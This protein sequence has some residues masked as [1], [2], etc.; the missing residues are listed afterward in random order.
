MNSLFDRERFRRDHRWAPGRMSE[1]LDGELSLPGRGRM[2]HHLAECQ[3]CRRLLA[4]LRQTV[5]ALARL[6]A[7]REGVDPRTIAASVQA[8]L[9]APD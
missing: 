5:S 7:P 8:R 4:G 2:E 9:D 3:Q 6:S 1:Y